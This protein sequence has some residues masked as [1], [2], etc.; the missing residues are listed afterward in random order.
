MFRSERAAM[1]KRHRLK[2]RLLL[3]ATMLWLIGAEPTVRAQL[4]VEVDDNAPPQQVFV[5][6]DQQFD[7]WAFGGRGNG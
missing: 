5:L 2:S 3:A 4:V 7:Q 1:F 6:N